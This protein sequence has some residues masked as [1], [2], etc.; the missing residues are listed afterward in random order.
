M[1][2]SAKIPVYK[3]RLPITGTEAIL[4]VCGDFHYGV[5]NI[6][7]SD[8]IN[9]LNGAVDKYQGNIFRIFTGDLVENQLKTSVGHNYD[10]ALAD[11][12]VQKA[13]MIG[14]LKA[15]NSYLYG[16]SNYKKL[17]VSKAAERTTINDIRSVGF[18][19][20]HEYRTRNTAGQWLSKEL[21]D[22]SKTLDC[23]TRAI[24][25]LTI[26][27]KKLKMEKTYRVFASH[28]PSKTDA[29]SFDAIT[30]AFKRKQSVIPGVDIMV[31]GHYHRRYVFPDGY[32]DSR[33]DEYKKILY[34]IN[35]S[36]MCNSEYAEQAGYPPLETGYYVNVHLPLDP[37][38]QV[39]AVV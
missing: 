16:A 5:K 30:R 28:R 13:D 17:D 20:N 12:A 25:E 34:V 37:A 8:I 10:V 11:P 32:F 21:H 7:K 19:G 35:P 26:Y 31:F 14:I 29:T 36:P 4:N 9:A 23:G 39:W 27:N 1:G 18:E 2:E 6:D 3:I 24:I 22:A 38:A 33:A 15:T